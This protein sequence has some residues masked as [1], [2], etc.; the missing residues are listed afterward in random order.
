MFLFISVVLIRVK[1]S[2]HD[3]YYHLALHIIL[4]IRLNII[5]QDQALRSKTTELPAEELWEGGGSNWND[6]IYG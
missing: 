4:L 3:Y 6:L 2:T 5:V 1:D